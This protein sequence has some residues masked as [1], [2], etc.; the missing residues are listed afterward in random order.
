MLSGMKFIY[1]HLSQVLRTY[2]TE[3]VLTHH[4]RTPQ[5]VPFIV[6]SKS[7]SS[8]PEVDML[9]SDFIEIRGEAKA[10]V[11]FFICNYL[12]IKGSFDK[13]NKNCRV[14]DFSNLR[15]FFS[16]PFSSLSLAFSFLF[17]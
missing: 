13:L 11:L 9:L 10:R 14:V 3:S 2:Q 12:D 16:L 7:L 8:D 1:Q 4:R 5:C 15:S 6:K 17:H